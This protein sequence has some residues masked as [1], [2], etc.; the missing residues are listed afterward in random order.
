MS[1]WEKAFALTLLSAIPVAAFACTGSWVGT[2]PTG[3]WSNINNWSTA[4]TC[5][6]GELGPG[7]IGL[8][9]FPTIGSQSSITVTQ[10]YTMGIGLNQLIFNSPAN[11]TSYTITYNATTGYIQFNGASPQLLVLAGTHVISTHLDFDGSSPLAITVSDPAGMLTLEQGFQNLG[12]QDVTFTGPGQLTLQWNGLNSIDDYNIFSIS[13][14]DF[15]VTSGT[16][17]NSNNIPIPVGGDSNGTELDPNNLLI[18]GGSVQVINSATVTGDASGSSIF[19]FVG[20]AVSN[21]SSLMVMNSGTVTGS[22]GTGGGSFIAAISN[23]NISD[24]S[25]VLISNSG[26]IQNTVS[27]IGAYITT[28]QTF[29]LIDGTATVQNSGM[30]GPNCFG[31][32]IYAET[33]AITEGSLLTSNTGQVTGNGIGVAINAVTINIAAAG[34][35]A[36]NGVFQG[37]AGGTTQVTNGGT[38]IAGSLAAGSSP[39]NML[40][41]G[42]YIQTSAGT[43]VINLANPSSFS[44]LNVTGT[45]QLAGN[46][47]V[48]FSPG[49]SVT[50]GSSYKIVT[51]NGGVTGQFADIIPMNGAF[52]LE[53]FPTYVLLT[54]IMGNAYVNYAEPLFSSINHINIRLDRQMAQ[55]R[56]RFSRYRV[57][58]ESMTA[59]TEELLVE[60]SPELNPQV[61]EKQ[62]QLKE[63]IVE[64]DRSWNFYFGPTGDIGRVLAKKQAQG[65]HY[66]TVGAQAGFDYAFS[67]LGV[68]FLFDYDH[69]HGRVDQQWGKFHIN[70][71]HGSVYATYIRK[72]EP[73]LSFNWI[74]G[75]GY[76]WYTICRNVASSVAKGTPQ[77]VEFDALVGMEYT[78]EKK[79]MCGMPEHLQVVPLINLQYIYLHV[80]KYLEHGAGMFG[81]QYDSQNVRS[82]R[83]TLGTRINYSWEWTNVVFKPEVNLGW[84]W[85]FFDKNRHIGVSGGGFG[86]NLLLPQPGR[87]VALAGIDFLVT[88][89]DKYGIEASYD[90]EWN[91]LYLDHF[92]Y[93]GCNFKF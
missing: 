30:V 65:F 71:T 32:A 9:T 42:S 41:Q 24:G 34:T 60:N 56:E 85:E 25:T 84:Q 80:N 15:I 44:Q 21:G 87:N 90:F 68:G 73:Q 83:S 62:E 48:A 86:T 72:P 3:N 75:G 70:Q 2:S 40:I 61:E 91:N 59:A 92:F 49:A 11:S 17:V 53:Y 64:C 58:F 52:L 33:I 29:N 13:P 35:M 16:F 26:T 37:I 22:V 8:A 5:I 57:K 28:T 66:D 47:E 51:A 77:G 1:I 69:I 67:D 23:C 89:F 79:G 20:M 18:T 19:P 38:V 7:D 93:V 74:L 45:A 78:F 12:T 63:R 10:D 88:F 6:P 39:G 4:P 55:L 54:S 31:S 81:L 43:L 36:G 76:E 50:P 14:G 46:L 82:L 27:G